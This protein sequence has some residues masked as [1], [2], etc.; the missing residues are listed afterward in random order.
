MNKACICAWCV[1]DNCIINILNSE[2]NNKIAVAYYRALEEPEMRDIT[3][4]LPEVAECLDFMYG[5]EE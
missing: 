4:H 2:M 1:N 5:K 3:P